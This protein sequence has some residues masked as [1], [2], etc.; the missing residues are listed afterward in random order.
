M[1]TERVQL[2][3]ISTLG[4]IQPQAWDA[5]VRDNHPLLSHAF[6]YGMEQH[7]CLSEASGWVPRYLVAHDQGRLVGAM[8]LYEKTN[9]WGEFV[10]DHAWADAYHR[11]G[12]SYYPKLVSAIP[13]SPVFGQK[14]LVERGHEQAL[15][16]LLLQGALKAAQQLHCSSLHVLFPL[17]Y[18]Q[19]FLVENGLL[20]RH[21]CQYHWRNQG[22]AGFEG[23]LATLKTKKRKNIRQERRRVAA[24]GIRLR[25]LD[26]NSASRTDWADFTRFYNSTYE[27]K[28]GAPIFNQPFFEAMAAA[29][30]ERI[31]LVLA[32]DDQGCVAGAL[33]YRSDRILYGRHWGCIRYHDAL[34]FE[35]CYYQGIEYCIEHGLELFEPGAQGPHKLARGFEPTL[36]SSAHWLADSRFVPA[37]RQFC[38]DE[39]S[40]V[41][42]HIDRELR[43]S[44]YRD[45]PAVGDGP[46]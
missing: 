26:G 33:M 10:F 8:P 15:Y 42:H 32:D 35:V 11:Y 16:P 38:E 24:A 44:A 37:V 43:H 36:T 4:E 31:I 14:L 34:H 12:L 5:L 6:L 18:E 22:Y 39:S 21:D 27:R 20:A 23:F 41:R 3:C 7:G 29:L 25:R 30:G 1:K 45:S 13:F 46:G 9:S 40:A 19:A 28:W 2:E 17:E